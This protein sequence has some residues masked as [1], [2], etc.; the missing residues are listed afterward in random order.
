MICNEQEAV[1][2]ITNHVGDVAN[3]AEDEDVEVFTCE[4]KMIFI[5]RFINLSTDTYHSFGVP[6]QHTEHLTSSY[7]INTPTGYQVR[8]RS[9]QTK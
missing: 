4:E 8:H 1:G 5:M 2:G 9:P 6:F 7:P 3:D